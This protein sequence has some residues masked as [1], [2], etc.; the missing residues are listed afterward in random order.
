[1]EVHLVDL[2]EVAGMH[3]ALLALGKVPQRNAAGTHAPQQVLFLVA[4]LHLSDFTILA[5]C[6]QAL[7]EIADVP[8]LNQP[9][10]ASR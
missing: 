4:P 5:V 10:L 9:V 1:M 7:R 3:E 8:D 2:L 6:G